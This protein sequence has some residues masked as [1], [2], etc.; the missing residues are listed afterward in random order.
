MTDG[1]LDALR[2]PLGRPALESPLDPA[3]RREK[4]RTLDELPSDLRDAVD[5]LTDDQLDTRYRPGGWTVRQI[6][7]HLADSHVHAYLRCKKAVLEDHPT[8]QTYDE[9]AWALAEEA[10]SAPVEMSLVLLEGL[11]RRWVAW[12]ETL[13]ASAWSRAVEHPEMGTVNVDQFLCIYA[14]HSRHHA[15]HILGLRERR[16]W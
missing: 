8:V 10:R 6:V 15:A 9:K 12:L 11:H 7:H 4:I 5:G 14:W 3:A 2:Y 13:P 16:D 1:E